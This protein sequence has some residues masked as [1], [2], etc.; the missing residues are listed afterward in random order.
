MSMSR[1]IRVDHLQKMAERY[2]TRAS[3]LVHVGGFE[4]SV[5]SFHRGERDLFLRTRDSEHTTFEL[6]EADIDCVL[7]PLRPG[8]AP[9]ELPAMRF[10]QLKGKCEVVPQ[11]NSW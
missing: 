7:P 2:G 10:T 1:T 8:G 4:N 6:V 3:E 5:Y 9:C 11:N